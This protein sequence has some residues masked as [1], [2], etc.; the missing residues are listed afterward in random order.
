MNYGYI[1]H[2]GL[3]ANSAAV[4]SS[5]FEQKSASTNVERSQMH[6]KVPAVLGTHRKI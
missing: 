6:D 5:N 1:S 3:A 2:Y 4:N